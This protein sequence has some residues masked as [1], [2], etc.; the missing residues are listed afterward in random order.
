[1]KKSIN[2]NGTVGDLTTILTND[3]K[4]SADDILLMI[5]LSILTASKILKREKKRIIG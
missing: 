4:P 2:H 3:F 1:M 5:I